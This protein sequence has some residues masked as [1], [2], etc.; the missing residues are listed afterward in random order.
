MRKSLW[1]LVVFCAFATCANASELVYTPV[2]PTFGGN[3]FNGSYLL[4]TAS[5]NNFE[6]LTNPKAAS[7]SST[8][9]TSELLREALIN[10]LIAQASSVAIDSILGTNG[11]A[12]DSGT[13][14]VAGEVITF[15]RSGGEIN[16][17]LTDPDGS[18]TQIQVPVPSM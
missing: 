4:S 7:T 9:S 14:S 18:Q 2:N 16:I 12:A 3:A 1:A 5:A 15:D 11:A 13:F 10:S 17:T 8:E 6:F